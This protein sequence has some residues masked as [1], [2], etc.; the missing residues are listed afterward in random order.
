MSEKER[1]GNKKIL[2]Y[3]KYLTPISQVLL[4]ILIIKDLKKKNS[5]STFGKYAF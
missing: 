4:K 2:I 3:A 5:I 1:R